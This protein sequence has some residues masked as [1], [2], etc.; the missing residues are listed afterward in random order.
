MSKRTCATLVAGLFLAGAAWAQPATSS[1]KQA[2]AQ[3]QAQPGR[4]QGSPGY[5]P[6]MMG[7]GYGP[8]M[9][10][11]GYGPGMMGGGYGPGM[12]GGGYGP[13]MMG[14]WGPRAGASCGPDIPN[15]TQ[16]QRAKL[17]EISRDA[18]QKH[19][20]L[21]QQMH[22]QPANIYPGGKFN[23]QAARAAYDRM[24]SI[25][26]QMFEHSLD[27]NKRLDNVLTPEQR[28]QMQRRWSR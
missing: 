11:G 17:D 24:A 28:E 6:G 19:W 7:G 14:G 16:E 22:Q 25:Q 10:G 27:V 12:M 5:G 8:G 3:S 20:A 1:S 9:M 13:G 15:L 2:D 23:E 18:T 26:K 4:D 21:M